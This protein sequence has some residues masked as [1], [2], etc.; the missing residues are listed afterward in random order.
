MDQWLQYGQNSVFC[1]DTEMSF[2]AEMYPY[3]KRDPK[4]LSQFGQNMTIISQT[5]TRLSNV[6]LLSDHCYTVQLPT[7]KQH[8]QTEIVLVQGGVPGTTQPMKQAEVCID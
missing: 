1:T 5:M 8:V 4:I 7:M 6:S 3:I 2:T